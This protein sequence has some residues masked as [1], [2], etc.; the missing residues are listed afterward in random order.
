MEKDAG[1]SGA[2]TYTKEPSCGKETPGRRLGEVF[3]F[4]LRG[5]IP[6]SRLTTAVSTAT[7]AT[8]HTLELNELWW[9]LLSCILEN[10]DKA[11]GKPGTFC[12]KE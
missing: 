5:E 7:A 8:T 2:S 10:F 11:G 3:D 1:V 4:T 6:D 9:H 12:R